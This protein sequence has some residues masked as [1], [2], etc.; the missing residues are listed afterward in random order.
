MHLINHLYLNQRRT[1]LIWFRRRHF[2]RGKDGV[3]WADQLMLKC[4]NWVL[5]NTCGTTSLSCWH[6]RY[7]YYKT[8]T[9]MITL[10]KLHHL[11]RRS[12]IVTTII[13]FKLIS[14]Y[15]PASVCQAVLPRLHSW[16]H[17]KSNRHIFAY[18][19]CYDKR[20]TTCWSG[21]LSQSKVK[22]WQSERPTT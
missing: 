20:R 17:Q 10:A 5:G 15:T 19:L 4:A 3:E 21:C 12:D 8:S 16:R 2:G 14:F 18:C 13:I 7:F 22:T 11:Q 6:R 9:P 1:M